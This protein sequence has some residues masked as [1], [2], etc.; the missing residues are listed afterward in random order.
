MQAL[1]FDFDGLILDTEMPEFVSWQQ[2]YR[3]LGYEL[4]FEAWSR[5]I[6]TSASAFDPINY[7]HS[8]TGAFDQEEII[9]ARRKIL[10]E[11]LARQKLLPGVLNYFN[12]AKGLGMK[13]AVASSS[14][15]TWVATHLKQHNIIHY[16]D[17]ICTREDVEIVKPNPALYL[18]ALDRL[19]IKADQAIAFEDSP[20]GITAAVDAGLFCVAVPNQLTAQMDTHHAHMHIPSFADVPLRVLLDQ[21]AAVAYD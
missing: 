9:L 21:I 20:N 13:L 12:D 16:F 3:S 19:G 10:S 8:L 1:I 6:G 7:L 4:P 15:I 14:P 11:L 18:T 2:I 17:I 5:C